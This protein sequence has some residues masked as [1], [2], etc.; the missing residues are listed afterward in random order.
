MD[1]RRLNSLKKIRL[2]KSLY[3]AYLSDRGEEKVRYR[4][5][6]EK[7]TVVVYK[8][9]KFI[10]A[11]VEEEILKVAIWHRFSVSQRWMEPDYTIFIDAAAGEWLTKAQ[12]GRWLKSD[13][14]RLKMFQ[15]ENEIFGSGNW[16]SE[17]TEEVVK[18]YLGIEDAPWAAIRKWQEQAKAEV[19]KR[20][21]KSELQQIDEFMES[22]PELPKRF[23]NDWLIRTAY[24]SDA[25]IVFKPGKKTVEGHCTRCQKEVSIKVKPVH[26]G[27]ATCPHCRMRMTLKSWGKQKGIR[28]EKNAGILQR[29][30]A[31][32]LCLTVYETWLEY[33]RE[34]DY[35]EPKIGNGRAYRFR[36]SNTFRIEEEYEFW[37]YRH[38]G[39]FRWCHARTH[40][41]GYSQWY[42]TDY[43]ILYE[44]NLKSIFAD[45]DLKYIPVDKMVKNS[46]QTH[47]ASALRGMKDYR[48][49]IEKLAKVGMYKMA[50]RISKEGYYY[51]EPEVINHEAVRLKDLL[52]LDTERTRQAVRM[53]V[54]EDEL[55]VLRAGKEAKKLLK[56]S[57]VKQLG[58]MYGRYTVME[59][60]VILARGNVESHVNY[61]NRISKEMGTGLRQAARDYEDFIVQLDTLEIERSKRNRYPKDFAKVHAD[62]QKIID[63]Q[64]QKTKAKADLKLASML[65]GRIERD[66]ELYEAPSEVYTIVWP[67]RREDFAREGQ[68]QHNCVGG[69]FDRAAAGSTT[70]FFLRK[71]EEPETPYATVEFN[72]GKLVQCRIAF[73]KDAPPEAQKYMKQIEKHYL[74]QTLLRAQEA[75]VQE[76][77][78]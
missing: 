7:E 3:E 16:A 57:W 9:Y 27:Q 10:V 75:K 52:R 1:K 23:D 40:G 28:A 37:E 41:M 49:S 32:E 26:N 34:T 55:K 71:K 29:T 24:A 72:R 35:K 31:G 42:A 14:C 58:E 12:D 48:W 70:V 21:W 51:R 38:T 53:D 22:V 36:L 2:P 11:E 63:I 6:E 73:N 45:T 61:I 66:R 20:K 43:C 44:S 76:K 17:K 60:A 33:T 47:I 64:K 65:K 39:V 46:E 69:Y 13:I 18:E 59:I 54:S 74:E 25:C 19:E 68:Q 78:G 5:K 67:V 77:A 62:L 15:M 30:K 8:N 4:F 50:W 56:D